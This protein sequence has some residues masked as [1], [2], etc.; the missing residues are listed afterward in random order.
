MIVI[1]QREN[2]RWRISVES[3]DWEVENI[4]ELK[5][6]IEKICEL[7]NKYGTIRNKER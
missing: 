3:E 4:E 1:R 5:I 7:K 2:T 6:L